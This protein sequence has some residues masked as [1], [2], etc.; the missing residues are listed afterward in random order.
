MKTDA[1]TEL[2][3]DARPTDAIACVGQFAI[4]VALRHRAGNAWSTDAGPALARPIDTAKS[5]ASLTPAGQ[6]GPRPQPS[7]TYGVAGG[8]AADTLQRSS[9]VTTSRF[10]QSYGCA[11]SFG[12]EGEAGVIGCPAARQPE[13]GGDEPVCEQTV[14]LVPELAAVVDSALRKGNGER[15]DR[16]RQAL[17]TALLPAGCANPTIS[18]SARSPHRTPS[19]VPASAGAR[20]VREDSDEFLHWNIEHV[21]DASAASMVRQLPACFGPGR[22]CRSYAHRP[23]G[24]ARFGA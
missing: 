24:G 15:G 4:Y 11:R 13:A 9:G 7:P 21:A 14:H 16:A 20:R 2:W 5:P 3:S 22:H 12:V 1:R 23:Q 10:R 8:K 6:P 18:P 19:R 17:R